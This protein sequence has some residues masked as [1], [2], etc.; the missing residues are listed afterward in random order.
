MAN[1]EFN[2]LKIKI[3]EFRRTTKEKAKNI[4]YVD[5]NNNLSTI[6][7]SANVIIYGRRGSG[8]T[9]LLSKGFLEA[10]NENIKSI[11]I[12][13]ETYKDHTY[14]N[15][16][17]NILIQIFEQA[18]ENIKSVSFWRIFPLRRKLRRE[19]SSLK[20]HLE[21]PDDYMIH[22][23][24]REIVEE[25]KKAELSVKNKFSSLTSS[26]GDARLKEI[27][28]K[29]SFEK[30]KINFLNNNI[31]N[32]RKLIEECIKINR[33]KAFFIMLDDY[34]LLNLSDQPFIIDYIFRLCKD[35]KAYFK[36]ST[37]RHRTNLYVRT[38]DSMIRGVQ[39]GA[40]HSSI[41]LDF[42]LEQ[43]EKTY[44]F[45]IKILTNISESCGISNFSNYFVGGDNGLPRIVWASGGV[46]RD[47][48][49]LIS[50]LL[51]LVGDKEN[52]KFDKNVIDKASN[53]VFIDK[54]QD[55][56][57]EY[58]IEKEIK[59]FFER[60]RNFCLIFNK[61]TV[62]LVREDLISSETLSKIN[63][64]VDHRLIHKVASN[65]SLT[66]HRGPFQ[67]YILDIGAYS[68]YLNIKR[69]ENRIYEI[70]ILRKD[71]YKKDTLIEI[72]AL[73][74][75]NEMN[76]KHLKESEDFVK[77]EKLRVKTN[78]NVPAE[79]KEMI[80]KTLFDF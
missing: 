27:N 33:L 59:L 79:Y 48:L 10:N 14:P 41:N 29:F 30:N 55:L 15:L 4:D 21:T 19:A 60:I 35:Q 46:P 71:P 72:R 73:G 32:Y 17:I 25:M 20:K 31:D 12:Q 2:N 54:L 42:N 22:Q 8:K 24:E 49:I 26:L 74:I 23:D 45:L 52:I 6:L 40:D 67:A 77:Q 43:F 51:D 1:K 3:E 78:K 80:Q 62:F 58:A 68:P 50:N 76:D 13:C 47:M 36:I 53:R 57:S 63:N 66:K 61:R 11:Y 34:Y 65:I 18:S 16:L 39:E 69:T 9:T 28:R 37:I 64:L 44:M 38:T 75:R 5:F 7:S 70:N 56:G